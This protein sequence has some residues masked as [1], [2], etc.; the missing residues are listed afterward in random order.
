MIRTLCPA[1]TL[2][3]SRR[4]WRGGRGRRGDGRS[5]REA[6]VRR[7]GREPV[8]SRG[9]VLSEG[10]PTRPEHL[11]SRLEAGHLLAHRPDRPG[12][13]VTGNGVLGRTHADARDPEQIRQSRHLVPHALI[14]PG[15]LYLNKHIVATNHRP[16]DLPEFKDVRRAVPVLDDC[17][18]RV[19]SS[20][21]SI[22]SCCFNPLSTEKGSRLDAAHARHR[23]APRFGTPWHTLPGRSGPGKTAL[24]HSFPR[25]RGLRKRVPGAECRCLY[26]TVSLWRR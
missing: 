14:D 1:R 6:E 12:H 16:V 13:V 3:L 21:H 15:R 23:I 11:V 10:A 5:L 20:M 18:H 22:S 7:L 9:R 8:R 19:R 4:A 24:T 2:P 17:L 25:V 26:G